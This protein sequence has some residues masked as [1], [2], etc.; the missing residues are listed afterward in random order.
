MKLMK[1][2]AAETAV[3]SIFNEMIPLDDVFQNILVIQTPFVNQKG[4]ALRQNIRNTGFETFAQL[5]RQCPV[6]LTIE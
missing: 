6:T 1:A 2:T 3:K 4:N 5:R